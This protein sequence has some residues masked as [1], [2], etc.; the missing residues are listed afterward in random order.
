MTIRDAAES[1]K[2]NWNEFVSAHFPSVGAF[3][4][5]WE[6]GE[7]QKALGHSIRR[8]VLTGNDGAWQGAALAVRYNLAFG[9]SYCYLPRGPVLPRQIWNDD[10]MAEAALKLIRTALEE[11][12]ARCVFIRMEPAVENPLPVLTQKPFVLPRFYTQPRFNAVVGLQKSAENIMAGF[13]AS[14]RNNIRKAERK[15]VRVEVKNAL[16]EDEWAK[17]RKMQAETSGRAGKNIYPTEKYFR[18]LVK[19]LPFAIFAAYHNGALSGI[20]IV[21]FFSRT[22][23]YLFGASYTEKLAVKISP[24]LHWVSMREAGKRGFAFYDLGGTDKCLWPTLTFFKQQFGGDT[25]TY[26]GNADVVIRPA[27]Y[28]AYRIFYTMLRERRRN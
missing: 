25:I 3:F 27:L 24:Y 4:Q 7:F 12:G 13:S 22:A 1:D 5:S 18:E 14:T 21:I 26:M 28:R 23:T 6:W 20:H 17:F 16:N 9:F 19:I 8:I 15:G 2:H 10:R 11:D